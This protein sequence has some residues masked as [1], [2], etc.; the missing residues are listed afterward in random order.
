MHS[1]PHDLDNVRRQIIHLE[2]EKAALEQEKNDSKSKN[3]LEKVI[4]KLDQ[5]KIKDSELTKV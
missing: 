1:I 3:Q 2:T 5:I 4:K